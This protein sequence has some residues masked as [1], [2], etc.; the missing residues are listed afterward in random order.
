MP[1]KSIGNKVQI[2]M[3]VWRAGGL[4]ALM[5]RAS[6][7]C[8]EQAVWLSARVRTR[9]A[10]IERT[11]CGQR[12]YLSLRD[13]G[14]SRWLMSYGMHEPL[15]T[16]LLNQEIKPG[17]RVVDIGAN[18]GYYTLQLARS[19]G[20]GGGVIAI[21]PLPD[22]VNLLGM[23]VDAN[24]HGNVRIYQA[25]VGPRDGVA[26]LHT[27]R[28]LGRS[29]LACQ[30]SHEGHVE[31][32]LWTLDALLQKEAKIDYIKMDIEGYETEAIKGMHGILQKHRPGLFIE[33]HPAIAGGK[34]T[35]QLLED[36]K[37]LGYETKYVVDK[38]SDHPVFAKRATAEI[39]AL[40]D[41]TRDKRVAQGQMGVTIFLEAVEG[42]AA[43]EQV[44]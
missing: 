41:L 21:E 24:G 35:I 16:R 13:P 34:A 12:M 42:P 29:S 14:M 4:F 25:A 33:T 6:G 17:M 10:L 26:E 36:L 3:R 7:Y 44:P 39:L 11:V 1:V 2:A 18:V 30:R 43:Q 38:A 23:N 32:P 15:A 27:S 22:N 40:D 5:R 37:R 31:V 28:N 19:V 9:G 20:Q 8:W